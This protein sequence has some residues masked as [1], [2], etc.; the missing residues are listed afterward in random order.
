[1]PA[2][3]PQV[4]SRKA[5]G[6][7]CVT[8]G[9]VS[10]QASVRK[11]AK[12]T[13]ENSIASKPG[14]G[15]GAVDKRGSAKN[16]NE[17]ET[18]Q[19]KAPRSKAHNEGEKM[20]IRRLPPGMT[21]PEFVTIL[22]SDWEVSK[23]KVDWLSYI[24][25]KVST[26]PSKPSRPSRAYLHLMRKDDIMPLSEVV[27]SSTWEDAKSTFTDP[28]LVGPPVLEFSVY[29]KIAGTKKRTDARQGTID[30]DP[31]FM[32]FL[33]D[34]AN[35]APM[36][37]S[38]DVEDPNDTAKV[39]T[40]VTTTP[41][42]EYLKEKKAN[43]GKDGASGKNSKSGGKGRGGSKEDETLNK[44]KGKDSKGDRTD[45]TPKETV[46]ILT[47]KAATEQAA[48]AAQKVASQIATTNASTTATTG[49]GAGAGASASADVPKSRRAGIAAAA[50]I[51]QR[52]LGLSPG[53][54]H[55][56]ARHDAAKAEAD[57]KGTVSSTKESDAVANVTP[58]AAVTGNSSAASEAPPAKSSKGRP[59][60]PATTK[61]QSGRRNRGGKNADK[62]KGT[63]ATETATVS[64]Q[65]TAVN[66][67]VI[68]KK[69][70]DSEVTTKATTT[71][72]PSSSQ[73][74]SSNATSNQNNN[75]QEPREKGTMKQSQKKPSSVSA[76]ATR[77]FVKHVSASQGVTDASLREAL[78]AFGTI[79]LVEIDKRKG[80]AYVDFSEHDAL[81]KAVT[82]SPISIGQASVQ[83][84]ERK[85]KK[86]VAAAPSTTSSKEGSLANGEK[87]KPSG[88]RGRRG[89]GG[90]KTGHGANSTAAANKEP[91][92]A[93]ASTGG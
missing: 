24:P 2:P 26:D 25:G 38:I 60:S 13:E 72:T 59:E 27:R 30:Q 22:G 89:R 88:G 68:L 16:A 87:E 42:V 93:A 12:G 15:K 36:R 46:K 44:R 73:V 31:E 20:V 65:P 62:G 48:E 69:K 63:A 91:A 23:G 67:P 50:R 29:K 37:E 70:N 81:A 64:A 10:D 61:S 79:T 14:K 78:E 76:S 47:K 83:V 85:D 6:T 28:A 9:Q 52:D 3:A 57:A 34:L 4:L 51:L 54:A 33:E 7:S 1:M 84:L 66:P 71:E 86:S 21:Q 17:G 58:L 74:P 55:R 39:E 90:G 5:N 56:R 77:A 19:T 43:K 82:A 53:S 45:K 32:A 18:P 49:A 75:K 92:A 80:F 35:P 11:R 8:P 40:K 41:L